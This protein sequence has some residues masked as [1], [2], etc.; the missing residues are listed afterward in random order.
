[1]PPDD[2]PRVQWPWLP[3]ADGRLTVDRLGETRRSAVRPDAFEIECLFNGVQGPVR[4]WAPFEMLGQLAN[5]AVFEQGEF[6]GLQSSPQRLTTNSLQAIGTAVLETLDDPLVEPQNGNREGRYRLSEVTPL[7]H[8]PW[9]HRY[10]EPPLCIAE[11]GGRQVFIP[12]GELLR[13]YFGPLSLG[14]NA[15]MAAAASDPG[16]DLVDFGS[17]GFVD[18]D[19]FRIAPNDALLD[20]GSALHL[21]MLLA[22]PDL[23]EL[24]MNTTLGLTFAAGRNYP[25]Y[26]VVVAP[27][28][29]RRLRLSGREISVQTGLLPVQQRAFS[30]SRILSDDRPP[31]FKRLIVRLPRGG[32]LGTEE[33]DF[34]QEGEHRKAILRASMNLDNSRRPGLSAVTRST[35]FQS[36]L[37]AF[38]NFAGVKI[39]YE[40]RPAASA[41]R[42]TILTKSG[43]EI[44]TVSMLPVASKGQAG[45]LKFRPS[46]LADPEGFEIEQP[47]RALLRDEGVDD[48]RT[49]SVA[50]DKLEFPVTNFVHA[51]SR[52]SRFGAGSL[53]FQDPLA[54]LANEVSLLEAPASWLGSRVRRPRRA[55]IGLLLVGD[56]PVYAFELERWSSHEHISLFLAMRRDGQTMSRANLSSIFR[57][58]VL[59]LGD[60][61]SRSG[62][63]GPWPAQGF[64]DLVGRTVPHRARRRYASCLAEDLD[65]LARAMASGL[66]KA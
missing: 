17:T 23:G 29:A 22:S 9:G 60:R 56:L 26:P 43:V 12:S 63:R 3:D 31:P 39:T 4:G 11:D 42:Q 16:D 61:T 53:L 38:P 44:D 15:F 54:S 10:E 57:Y 45:A 49:V 36:M 13:F 8:E 14:A 50:A 34:P 37:A 27:S 66:P 46:R 48:A 55:A 33:F 64:S 41:A 51:F 32:G 18:E 58:A 2:L 19:V 62:E 59:R 7:A 24:W 1:M 6:V 21:A 47:S 25:Q 30:A 28:E 65:D 52:L 35:L 5:G 40:Q 20:R